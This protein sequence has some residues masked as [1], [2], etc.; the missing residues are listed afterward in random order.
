M[1]RKQ[2]EKDQFDDK[3]MNL[4]LKDFENENDERYINAERYVEQTN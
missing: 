4:S 3:K 1:R 2:M